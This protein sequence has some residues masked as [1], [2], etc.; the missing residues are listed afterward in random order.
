MNAGTNS[1][2]ILAWQRIR[3]MVGPSSTAENCHRYRQASMRLQQ[4]TITHDVLID[5]AEERELTR[6]AFEWR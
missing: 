4:L 3:L 2:Q 5:V 1:G 6:H